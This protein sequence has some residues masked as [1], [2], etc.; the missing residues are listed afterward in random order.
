[1]KYLMDPEYPF[2][3]VDPLTHG[4]WAFIKPLDRET[5]FFIFLINAGHTLRGNNIMKHLVN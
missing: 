2:G 3:H 4:Y 5:N 1:M